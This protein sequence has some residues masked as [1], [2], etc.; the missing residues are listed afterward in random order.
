MRSLNTVS[1][2]STSDLIVARREFAAASIDLDGSEGTSLK[3]VPVRWSN[4]FS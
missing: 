1:L 3:L 2:I 4:V